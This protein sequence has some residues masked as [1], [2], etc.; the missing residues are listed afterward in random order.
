MF[1]KI[2]IIYL[3]V[4]MFTTSL[5]PATKLI[6]RKP[7]RKKVNYPKANS[8]PDWISGISREYPENKYLISTGK[9]NSLRMAEENARMNMSELFNIKIKVRQKDDG[10]VTSTSTESLLLGLKLKSYWLDEN[11]TYY[12]L[13]VIDREKTSESLKNK[14]LKIDN[15]I[16]KLMNSFKKS[17][18]KATKVNILSKISE[19]IKLRNMY[20]LNFIVLSKN[21][22]GINTQY[23]ENK[24]LKLLKKLKK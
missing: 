22:N 8:K 1:K 5:F 17:E 16:N 18:I 7:Y 24:I 2:S 4:F 3:L 14:I 23:P 20:N 9:A 12:V 6:V 13:A 10:I 21:K 11:G 15:D 19:K